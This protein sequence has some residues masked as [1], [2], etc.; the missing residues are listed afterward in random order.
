MELVAVHIVDFTNFPTLVRLLAIVE[1]LSS[2]VNVS[3]VHRALLLSCAEVFLKL[4]SQRNLAFLYLRLQLLL[5]QL[6]TLQL[7]LFDQGHVLDSELELALVLGHWKSVEESIS[8]GNRGSIT[9]LSLRWAWPAVLLAEND[10][11][12]IETGQQR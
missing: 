4:L 9:S 7:S 5:L 8:V 6:K 10:M 1:L 3:T 2:I 11:D 12:W